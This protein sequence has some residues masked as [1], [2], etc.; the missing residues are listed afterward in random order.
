MKAEELRIGNWVLDNRGCYVQ[1]YSITSEINNDD[2]SD[3]YKPITLTEE[4]LVKFGYL[5]YS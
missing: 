4:I 3:L 5:R 2:M 1:V